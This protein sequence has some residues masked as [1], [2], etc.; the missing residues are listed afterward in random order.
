MSMFVCLFV[1][2][3]VCMLFVFYIFICVRIYENVS[4]RRTRYLIFIYRFP[5]DGSQHWHYT[6][7]DQ[8]TILEFLVVVVVMIIIT[9][10]VSIVSIVCIASSIWRHLAT[11]TTGITHGGGKS[12]ISITTF[13]EKF[14]VYHPHSDQ[15]AQKKV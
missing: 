13:L 7:S 14:T 4:H 6:A 11:T 12:I 5:I 15:A 3:Y 2:M 8:P 9:N 1:C 10:I